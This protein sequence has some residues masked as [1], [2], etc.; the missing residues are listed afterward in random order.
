MAKFFM[1]STWGSDDPTRAAMIFGHGNVLAKA[2]H[3][4]RIFLLGEA[5]VLVREAVRKSLFPVGWPP[6]EDQW[7]ESLS[8]GIPIG[9]CEA[10]RVARG[11]E[12]EEIT[13]SGA[14]QATP[15]D[16]SAGC[17]WAD[18]VISEG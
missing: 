4:V 12:M 3:E 7:Q 15:A 5:S 18:H 6:L 1:K 9:I 17:E 11:V 14:V 16:F 8:L 10:C 13:S 2:G